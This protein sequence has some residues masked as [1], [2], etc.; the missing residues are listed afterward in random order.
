VAVEV[1]IIIYK[2]ILSTKNDTFTVLFSVS[3]RTGKL[4]GLSMINDYTNHNLF[5]VKLMT[6]FR[7]SV[8]FNDIVPCWR[9]LLGNNGLSHSI[10]TLFICFR[11]HRRLYTTVELERSNSRTL[12]PSTLDLSNCRLSNPRTIDSRSLEVFFRNLTLEVSCNLVLSYTRSLLSLQPSNSRTVGPKV[13][14]R[15]T[16]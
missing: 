9:Y 15:L 4:Q 7:N 10:S 12:E 14:L 5:L 8:L 1:N 3:E 13:A 6:I 11:L 16:E 2:Y